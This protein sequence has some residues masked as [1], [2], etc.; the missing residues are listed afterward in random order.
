MQK[1]RV[2][3]GWA[4]FWMLILLFWNIIKTLKKLFGSNT[5]TITQFKQWNKGNVPFSLFNPSYMPIGL[6]KAM[7]LGQV[8]FCT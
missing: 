3:G 2:K 5:E 8:F 1:Y 4:M 7:E 6:V